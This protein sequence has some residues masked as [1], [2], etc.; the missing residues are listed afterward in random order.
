MSPNH[1]TPTEPLKAG[2]FARNFRLPDRYGQLVEL[3]DVLKLGP[4]V[5]CFHRD[6]WDTLAAADPEV[7]HIQ[8]AT[9]AL[10]GTIIRIFPAEN[11]CAVSA[12]DG[13]SATIRLADVGC[14]TARAYG[15]SSDTSTTPQPPAADPLAIRA[16][17]VVGSDRRIVLA[18]IDS[19]C[20]SRIEPAMILAALAGLRAPFRAA[21]SSL[22]TPQ[23]GHS[24]D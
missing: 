17:L 9:E 24:D 2:A 11:P 18:F 1:Q 14:R 5:V 20:R 16:S 4:A 13:L 7:P 15:L 10:G 12:P 22:P 23:K 21:I 6:D 8:R 3:A 19:D